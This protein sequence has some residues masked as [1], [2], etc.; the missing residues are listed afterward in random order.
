VSSASGLHGPAH[1]KADQHEDGAE[2]DERE[3]VNG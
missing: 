3:R 2:Q 1:D